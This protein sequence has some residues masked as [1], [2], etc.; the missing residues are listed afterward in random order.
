MLVHE[1][2]ERSIAESG[3]PGGR[4]E[5]AM[6]GEPAPQLAR[7]GRPAPKCAVERVAHDF[8]QVR[9]LFGSEALLPVFRG[10][11]GG[12]VSGS[13][14]ASYCWND[15]S[16]TRSAARNRTPSKT[17]QNSAT[18]AITPTT[19]D[20]SPGR[21]RLALVA[22]KRIVSRKN[23]ASTI[24]IAKTASAITL[25]SSGCA[26][27]TDSSCINSRI[28]FCHA[29]ACQREMNATIAQPVAVASLATRKK[30]PLGRMSSMWV[31]SQLPNMPMPYPAAR[32]H[33][34]STPCVKKVRG[35]SDGVWEAA[36]NSVPSKRPPVENECQ[37]SL[38][39]ARGRLVTIVL[40]AT[41]G[42]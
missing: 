35:S 39:I 25:T 23:R 38:V 18:A 40:R 16:A 6:V 14:S 31:Q 33:P 22:T 29:A 42:Q 30:R 4:S 32:E 5:I 11:A 8:D 24:R 15:A 21:K 28:E 37:S 26:V 7:I 9:R 13:I 10:S 19:L 3:K 1:P 12:S 27:S 34:E 17:D 2:D 20:T 36:K 41:C